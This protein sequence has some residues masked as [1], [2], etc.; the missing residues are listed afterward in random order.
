MGRTRNNGRDGA[1]I[2][3][4][5]WKYQGVDSDL[6]AHLKGEERDLED[7]GNGPRQDRRPQLVK[8]QVV[9]IEVRLLKELADEQVPRTVRAVEFAVVCPALGIRL[10]GTDIEALRVALWSK[11][12]SIHAIRWERWYLVQISPASSYVG[13]IETGFC[14]SEST[15]YRGVARDGTALMRERPRGRNYAEW[16]YGLWPGEY[17]DRNGHVMACIPA[18]EANERSLEEFRARIRELRCRLSELVRP[19]VILQTLANLS[20]VGLPAPEQREGGAR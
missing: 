6:S 7:D 15:I 4:W 11:L 5:Y 8:E 19:E 9:K 3:T 17:Q 18:T 16:R 12:E 10:Q 13:D 1:L 14:L 20:G 2:D